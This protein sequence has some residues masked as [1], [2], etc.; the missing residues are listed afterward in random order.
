MEFGVVTGMSINIIA[1][2][3]QEREVHGFDSFEGLPENWS[4]HV[5]TQ[6]SFSSKG[7][8]PKVRP[9]VR[10]YKGWCGETLE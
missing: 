10:L 3:A 4:G 2:A 5:E 1:E 7:Q 8:L 6:G 9:S